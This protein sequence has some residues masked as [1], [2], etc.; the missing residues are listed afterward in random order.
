[1]QEWPIDLPGFMTYDAHN[2]MTKFST[3]SGVG[4]KTWKLKY[5]PI[6]RVFR[7]EEYLGESSPEIQAATHYYYKGGALVQ[8]Y[9]KEVIS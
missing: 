3:G 7:K 9:Y 1:M 5:D 8:E 4:M 2:R 6:G